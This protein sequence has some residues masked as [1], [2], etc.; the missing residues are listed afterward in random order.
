MMDISPVLSTALLP[1]RATRVDWWDGLERI[2]IRFVGV[3]DGS[4]NGMSGEWVRKQ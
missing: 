3:C 2:Y 1:K 4:L